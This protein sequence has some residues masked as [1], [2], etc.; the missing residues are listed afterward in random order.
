MEE[1]K[2]KEAIMAIQNWLGADCYKIAMRLHPYGNHYFNALKEYNSCFFDL[3][4]NFDYNKRSILLTI[5]YLGEIKSGKHTFCLELLNYFNTYYSFA[6]FFLNPGTLRLSCTSVITTVDHSVPLKI[7]RKT[8]E[9]VTTYC[10]NE[11]LL[12]IINLLKQDIEL[13]E[14]IQITF[15]D[16]PE[17]KT[18]SDPDIAPTSLKDYL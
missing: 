3:E 15:G 10:I 1:P 8:L 13:E 12:K 18:L 4:I 14:A 2:I 11:P 16:T 9:K 17:I 7:L 5:I 6:K